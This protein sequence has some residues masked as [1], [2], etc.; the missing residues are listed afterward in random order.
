M[1]ISA[2][3]IPDVKLIEQGVFSDERGWFAESWNAEKFAEAG[4]PTVFVQD[5]QSKSHRNVL[6]GLHYQ[7]GKPQGKLVRVLRGQIFDVAVDLR[8]SS[9][10]FGKWAGIELRGTDLI[11]SLEILW[12]PEGFAHGFL[13]QSE[14][15]EVA[16]KTT[17]SYYPQGE[18]TILW[19]DP[20]VG[21]NWPL[22]GSPLVSRKDLQGLSWASA[23]SEVE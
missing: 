12:I 15:A 14:S 18:R 11:D 1:K 7:V 9:A 16:Y 20:E 8:R 10:T 5:N 19:N 2:T 22:V 21:V 6:R 4:V 23:I 3:T 17:S 13:V